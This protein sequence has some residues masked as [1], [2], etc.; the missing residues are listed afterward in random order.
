MSENDSLQS[1]S[2]TLSQAR[3]LLAADVDADLVKGVDIN[4]IISRLIEIHKND[5]S[6]SIADRAEISSILEQIK[7]EK[8]PKPIELARGTNPNTMASNVESDYEI[9]KVEHESAEGTVNDFINYF[10]NRI[11]RIKK[12]IE[13]RRI[14]ANLAPNIEAIKKYTN[15]RE[16]VIAGIVSN[17]IITKNKNLMVVVE[18]QTADFKIIFINGNSA[19]SKALFESAS[20]IIND[21]V[22]AIKGK[23]SNQFIIANEIIWPDIPIKEKKVID[24]DIAIAFISDIHV[25]SKQFMSKNFSNMIRWLNGEMTTK[26]AA[27]AG[28]IKYLVMAGDVADGV[29]IYPDQEYDLA[30]PDVYLQY[31]MLMNFIGSIPD[32]I[33]V[34]IM[35]GNHDAVQRAE[36]QPELGKDLINDFKMDNVHFVSNPCKLKLHGIDVLSYHGTSLDSMISAIPDMSYARPEKAMIEILKRRHL[37]PI[38]GGNVVVPSR[39]DQM[40]IEE[41]PDILHMGHIHKN[42]LSEYHGVTV[43]NSGT[44]QARTNFQVRTGHIPT[45]CILPVYETKTRNVTMLNF[46]ND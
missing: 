15:G 18:D 29:G 44:W 27:L 26:S 22:I 12:I 1:L 5:N 9:Y 32:Y 2:R 3:I 33:E 30:V 43:V 10:R 24:E 31:K 28:K 13:N 37:S 41:V 36:P 34:F 21:E 25:G 39:N 35:P 20:R 38:Y 23:I 17:K 14:A 11:E 8:M 45:P 42:G 16:V 40:V 46:D 7:I 4:V 6:I 19:E